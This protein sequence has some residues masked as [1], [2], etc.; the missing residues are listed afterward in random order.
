M[1]SYIQNKRG[2]AK[3]FF[4]R[5]TKGIF[6][7]KA[8]NID[9]WFSKLT[10]LY[11]KTIEEYII[12]Q[13]MN[14]EEMA[15]DGYII[16]DE[17]SQL[18]LLNIVWRTCKHLYPLNHIKQYNF[19]HCKESHFNQVVINTF[20]SYLSDKP[21]RNIKILHNLLERVGII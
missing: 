21:I 19:L 4:K 9:F 1:N 15:K 2:S 11:H 18:E 10:M 20:E 17:E 3:E 5:K 7:E 8:Q 16:N 12:M 13:L 14:I 6:T